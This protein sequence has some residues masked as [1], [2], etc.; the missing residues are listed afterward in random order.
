MSTPPETIRVYCVD[1]HPIVL[2]GLRADL[3]H[4]SSIRIVG[5]TTDPRIALEEI[6]ALGNNIDVVLT[7]IEMPHISGF[8]I[9][10]TLKKLASAPRVIFFTY[11]MTPEVQ[12]K[13]ERVKV[14][15]IVYKSA[16]AEVI[17]E[18]IECVYH[19][20][21]AHDGIIYDPP[22]GAHPFAAASLTEA[23]MVVLRCIVCEHLSTNE[24]AEKLFRS[25][26]TIEQHRK[27][28]MEKLDVHNVMQLMAYG[29]HIGLCSNFT[30][31]EQR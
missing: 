4:A 16:S 7:D 17:V 30:R 2:N 15:G 20:L 18:S 14:D 10:T 21:D 9:C 28:I 8:D 23:E 6:L 25:R 3:E 11:H 29:Y 19:G 26:H 24:I 13:A 1:D 22:P 27:N 5:S 31:P 12:Y